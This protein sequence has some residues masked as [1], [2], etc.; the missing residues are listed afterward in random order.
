MGEV[1]PVRGV[2]DPVALHQAGNES[3][4]HQLAHVVVDGV[5][6]QTKVVAQLL[7]VNR[8][9]IPQIAEDIKAGLVA[10]DPDGVIDLGRAAVLRQDAPQRQPQDPAVDE[11]AAILPFHGEVGVRSHEEG[12]QVVLYLRR[13]G[14]AGGLPQVAFCPQALYL[15]AEGICKFLDAAA[16]CFQCRH[17][18]TQACQ[19]LRQQSPI[20]LVDLQQ[21]KAA[22]RGNGQC[23]DPGDQFCSAA[24]SGAG[25][26]H[27]T[28]G[29]HHVPGSLVRRQALHPPHQG[30][31]VLPPGEHGVEEEKGGTV[32][33]DGAVGKALD[34]PEQTLQGIRRERDLRIQ[35]LQQLPQGGT[36]LVEGLC[37]PNAPGLQALLQAAQGTAVGPGAQVRKSFQCRVD[38]V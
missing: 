16:L 22:L 17:S 23:Q 1:L 21:G 2:V 27:Q 28:Q 35:V 4:V 31:K 36:G 9:V 33:A 7:A 11:H 15:P 34:I 30:L 12:D 3:R 29:E 6:C 8:R 24:G 13:D 25:L 18:G 14:Q 19:D 10:D 26:F 5:A 32:G 38:L 37:P 20:V